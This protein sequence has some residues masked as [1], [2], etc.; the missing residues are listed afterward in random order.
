MIRNLCATPYGSQESTYSWNVERSQDVETGKWSYQC[1]PDGHFEATVKFDM[2]YAPSKVGDVL[3][4][5]YS[6]DVPDRLC[7]PRNATAQRISGTD[8]TEGAAIT[9]RMGWVAGRIS[10]AEGNHELWIFR[11]CG[12]VTLEGC[13]VFSQEDLP[14]VQD[15]VS[16]GVLEIPWFATPPSVSGTAPQ[17]ALLP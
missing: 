14:L 11:E 8:T 16:A 15:I 5:I 6:C 10:E 12:W 13:A 7:L 9:P 1:K 2:G 17:P 4:C 3:V